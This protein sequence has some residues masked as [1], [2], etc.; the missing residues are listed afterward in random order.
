MKYLLSYFIVGLTLLGCTTNE[1]ETNIQQLN[2]STE[3]GE[4][5]NVIYPLS[6]NYQQNGI[7]TKAGGDFGSNWES[8]LNVTVYYRSNVVNSCNESAAVSL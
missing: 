8:Y 6:S 1:L 7:Q 5:D 3:M 2:I 4:L